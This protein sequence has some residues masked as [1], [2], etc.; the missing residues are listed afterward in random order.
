MIYPLDLF[1]GVASRG[2]FQ[3][4]NSNIAQFQTVRRVLVARWQDEILVELLKTKTKKKS[5]EIT[6]NYPNIT[7]NVKL[8]FIDTKTTKRTEQI[9]N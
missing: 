5:Q 8:N 4:I 2:R 9:E 6:L 3:G 7:S 1:T